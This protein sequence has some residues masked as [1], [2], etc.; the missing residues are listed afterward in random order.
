MRSKEEI[1]E[2]LRDSKSIDVEI[3]KMMEPFL[4][5]YGTFVPEQEKEDRRSEVAEAIEKIKDGINNNYT[6]LY[7]EFKTNNPTEV[8]YEELNSTWQASRWGK[9]FDTLTGLSW[10]I[11]FNKTGD[12]NVSELCKDEYIISGQKHDEQSDLTQQDDSISNAQQLRNSLARLREVQNQIRQLERAQVEKQFDEAGKLYLDS[13]LEQAEIQ[14]RIQAEKKEYSAIRREVDLQEELYQNEILYARG[15]VVSAK[16]ML[17]NLRRLPIIK[18]LENLQDY[19]YKLESKLNTTSNPE[20]KSKIE[21]AISAQQKII[22]NYLNTD[23]GQAYK[24]AI[25]LEDDSRKQIADNKALLAKSK[26]FKKEAKSTLS[27]LIHGIKSEKSSM[28]PAK[29]NGFMKFIGAIKAK[30]GIGKYKEEK[31]LG[32]Q[33]DKIWGGFKEKTSGLL[34]EVKE[35]ASRTGKTIEDATVGKVRAMADKVLKALGDHID[36]RVEKA[37][38][39]LQGMQQPDQSQPNPEQR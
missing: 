9:F 24:R 18:E 6:K 21:R 31:N 13:K 22:E 35:F 10:A 14:K 38:A 8:E 33:F 26:A 39:K 25:I 17:R 23:A 11:E 20:E 7:E 32:E 28:V 12:K 5:K 27:E 19:M 36:G 37:K 34:G 1:L 30:L 2:Y 4:G 3:E 29:K 16:L 15:N